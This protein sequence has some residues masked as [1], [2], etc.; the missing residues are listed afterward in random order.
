MSR[1]TVR[2]LDVTIDNMTRSEALDRARG[3]L[4]SKTFHQVV[5]PGPEF[6]LEATAHP[7]FRQILNDADL[8]LPDGMGLHIGTR[9]TGQRLRQRV[10]GVDFVLDLVNLAAQRGSR[11]FLY[12]GR[13]GVAEK[14]A[15]R[16]LHDHPGLAVVGVESGWRDSWNAVSDRRVIERIHL[17]KPDILLVALGAPKQELW[18]HRHR[19][20][21]HEVSIA[22]G[23]G[24]TLDY[25]AGVIQRPPKIVRQAGF[26]WLYTLLTARQ[27]YQ[28]HFRRQ[29]VANAT[30]RFIVEV[31]RHHYGRR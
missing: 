12:G 16:L 9:L 2:L 18:I 3:F 22:I 15:E 20:H 1:N 21:L 6:L 25:L 7:Q 5:T 27:F 30:F 29:R 8:S 14:A 17:A 24:R 31:A 26:E 28:P 10:P 19:H 4:D 13:P 11:V 23:V